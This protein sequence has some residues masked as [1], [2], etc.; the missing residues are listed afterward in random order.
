MSKIMTIFMV[1]ERLY[2]HPVFTCEFSDSDALCLN[3]GLAGAIDSGNWTGQESIAYLHQLHSSGLLARGRSVLGN[4]SAD[5]LGLD[6]LGNGFG[7]GK[8]VVDAGLQGPGQPQGN[9]R[10]WVGVARFQC[11]IGL[12]ADSGQIRQRL[13]GKP[14][15]KTGSFEMVQ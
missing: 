2:R 11:R 15:R 7:Q 3:K 8:Q 12:A 14:G 13:L 10:R 4:R 9:L 1:F 6:F 5:Q